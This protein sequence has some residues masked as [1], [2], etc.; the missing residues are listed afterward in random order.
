MSISI[1]IQKQV[2]RFLLWVKWFERWSRI[3]QRL[4]DKDWAKSYK[5]QEWHNKQIDAIEATLKKIT[6]KKDGFKELYDA[7]HHPAFF[8]WLVDFVSAEYEQPEGSCDC[9]DFAL[10]S[11]MNLFIS[12]SPKILC[13]HWSNG[14]WP[15]QISGHAVCVYQL[16][17]HWGKGWETRYGHIGNWGNFDM[18]VTLDDVIKDVVKRAGKSDKILGYK[19]Y[20]PEELVFDK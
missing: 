9:E 4:F 10:W 12:Y 11:A 6:W 2:V 19:I 20:K 18:F 15:W 5:D 14:K 17:D 13:V 7:A 1:W 8:Q 3:Y 16:Y